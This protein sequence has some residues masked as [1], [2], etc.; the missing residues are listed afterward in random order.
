[1]GSSPRSTSYFF[2]GV[3]CDACGIATPLPTVVSNYRGVRERQSLSRIRGKGPSTG[4]RFSEPSQQPGAPV[5]ASCGFF[6]TP[7]CRRGNTPTA[8]LVS[9]VESGAGL[10]RADVSGSCACV[11]IG[12]ESLGF[13][14]GWREPI[15]DLQLSHTACMASDMSSCHVAKKKPLGACWSDTFCKPSGKYIMNRGD[16]SIKTVVGG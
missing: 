3:P 1:M 12:A 10:P 4:P 8:S 14:P 7:S 11:A 16:M 5:F 15:L 9:L 6:A 2:C 13:F